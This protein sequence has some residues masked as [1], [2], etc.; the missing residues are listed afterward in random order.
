VSAQPP[1]T[2]MRAPPKSSAKFRRSI[3]EFPRIRRD[4][5]FKKVSEA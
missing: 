2:A 3:R 4:I 5:A 1:S